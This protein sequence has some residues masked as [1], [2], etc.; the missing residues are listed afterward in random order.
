MALACAKIRSG[1]RSGPGAGRG[2]TSPD[3]T[4]PRR[5]GERNRRDL[6]SRDA[7]RN[8]LVCKVI[9]MRGG[10]EGAFSG[11]SVAVPA[12]I[13]RSP[14]W[15]LLSVLAF[16]VASPLLLAPRPSSLPSCCRKDGAHRCG[17]AGEGA[18][19]PGDGQAG[20]LPAKCPLFSGS[21]ASAAGVRFTPAPP[22]RSAQVPAL[23]A[24]ASGRSAEGPAPSRR[25][26]S[27]CPKRA[28]PAPVA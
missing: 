24:S 28:P 19:P 20:L 8:D 5:S 7:A 26:A 3:E 9:S 11:R 22:A 4:S 6:F 13:R 25:F 27:D 14:A 10:L 1:E 2:R 16:W 15:I 23:L 12:W 18:V 21:V 17:M